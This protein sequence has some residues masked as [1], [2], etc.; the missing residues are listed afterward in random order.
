MEANEGKQHSTKET[1]EM[2]V[3]I[4]SLQ[5]AN[6][7]HLLCSIKNEPRPPLQ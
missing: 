1:E 3:I 6:L 5:V 7:K 2:K 4:L